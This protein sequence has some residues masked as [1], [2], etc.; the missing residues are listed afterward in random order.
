MRVIVP[1][2]MWLYADEE[3]T[4]EQT[5]AIQEQATKP[6]MIQLTLNDIEW[7]NALTFRYHDSN[8]ERLAYINPETT[9]ALPQEEKDR[10]W[11]AEE[12]EEPLPEGLTEEEVK[13]REDEA[14]KKAS[15]E[16]EETQTLAK[17]RGVR[18]YIHG[19]G[20]LKNSLLMAR[21]SVANVTKLVKPIWKNGR[22]LAIEMP[23]MGTEVE[24]GNHQA[25]VEVTVNGQQFSTNN[26]SFLYNQVDPNMTDE[27]LRKLEEEEMKAMKKGKPGKK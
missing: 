5:A 8:V 11:A 4:E 18:I 15:E 9:A 14:I 27:E 6:I 19:T 26:I 7:I 16:T 23:D 20:F 10:L 2:F 3:R 17:R 21:V 13:K 25:T 12:P 1:P 24:Q 22:K